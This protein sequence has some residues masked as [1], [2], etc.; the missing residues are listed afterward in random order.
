MCDD[1]FRAI[2]RSLQ[3]DIQNGIPVLLG[4]PKDQLVS[5]DP[6][7]VD[8]NID[9]PKMSNRRL[10]HVLD[11]TQPCDIHVDSHCP[12]TGGL[13]LF[14]RF[15]C[16]LQIDIGDDHIRP[17]TSQHEGHGFPNALSPSRHQPL[18]LQFHSSLLLVVYLQAESA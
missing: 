2:K 3:I 16:L 7:I 18:F 17:V 8:Q 12:T 5:S 13:H 10:D 1:S 11:V 14:G 9:S 15:R 6:R 4:H